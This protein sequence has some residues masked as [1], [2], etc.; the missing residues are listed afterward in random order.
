M[1][2]KRHSTTLNN[3]HERGFIISGSKVISLR[4]PGGDNTVFADLN[5]CGS[6]ILGNLTWTTPSGFSRHFLNRHDNGW[7]S[8]RYNDT[9][10]NELRVKFEKEVKCS[11]QN[12]LVETNEKTMGIPESYFLTHPNII[13]MLERETQGDCY[14]KKGSCEEIVQ[15]ADMNCKSYGKMEHAVRDYYGIKK[16]IT[17]ENDGEKDN[18]KVEIKCPRINTNGTWMIQHLKPEH[19]F[20]AVL[21]ALLTPK[22]GLRT[23]LISKSDVFKIVKPQRGE[24]W[25]VHNRDLESHAVPIRKGD[26]FNI[27]LLKD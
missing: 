19:D 3:L 15:L 10:L 27:L 4:I 6:I 16:T 7:R 1:E 2:S 9:I 18:I 26:N 17:T 24:G 21:I 20:D 11:T 23:M 25:L 14:R 13:E 5:D 12:D 8:V 22:N